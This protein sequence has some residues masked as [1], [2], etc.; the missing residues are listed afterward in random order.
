MIPKVI[1]YC[2][3]GKNP[4][5]ER[6][7]KCIQ[8]WKI[9]CPDY[10]IICWDESNFDIKINSFVERAYSEKK[11][12][13]VTDYARLWVVY[14]YGG[15]YLD[16]DVELLKSLDTLRQHDLYLGCEGESYINTGLGFGAITK[17]EIIR[18]NMKIYEDMDFHNMDKEFSVRPC[19]FYTTQLLK[20]KGVKFPINC[21]TPVGNMVIY[22]N[23][24]FN[25][26]DW[27]KQ[28]LKITPNTYSIHHYSASW[29]TKEQKRGTIEQHLYQIYKQKYG[30]R[31]AD[32]WS[33][34]YWSKKSNGGKGIIKTIILRIF[35]H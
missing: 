28:K 27:A 29:M 35:R 24:Y 21:I 15:F 14:N 17:N 34:F 13:F 26:Y 7:E 10:E 18:E 25:P 5:P 2:W 19:P 11:W 20:E 22:P 31:I 3:F 33:Y 6:M 1:H 16:T 4:I 8:S 30:K 12:A 23:E 9:M 32:I